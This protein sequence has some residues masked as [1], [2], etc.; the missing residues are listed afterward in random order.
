MGGPIICHD[1]T[2]F[3]GFSSGLDPQSLSFVIRLLQKIQVNS[4]DVPIV[5]IRPHKLPEELLQD[6]LRGK[7]PPCCKQIALAHRLGYR[8]LIVSYVHISGQSLALNLCVAL[9]RI[10]SLGMEASLHIENASQLDVHEFA[11]FWPVLQDFPIT[12]LVFGDKESLLDPFSTYDVLTELLKSTPFALE[13]HGHNAY[14][15]ATANAMSAMRAGV[16]CVATAVGGIGNRGHAPFEEVMMGAKHL[17]REPAADIDR[18][19]APTCAAIAGYLGLKIPLDKAVVGKNIFAHES[20]L[21]VHGV[22]KNP[23]LYEAFAPEEVGLTRHLVVGKHAGTTSLQVVLRGR[24]I[25]V[26]DRVAQNLL[27]IVRRRVLEQKS[28]LSDG[29]LLQI[30]LTERTL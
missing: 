7:L 12:T 24:G 3:E 16:R 10:Q 19:L 18:E 14:G 23:A 27:K 1:Q 29:Q 2:L 30:Y 21:H 22:T 26:S 9:D 5:D 11:D 6:S 28:P 17:L 25:E 15:L 20:G 8:K 13:F 4:M